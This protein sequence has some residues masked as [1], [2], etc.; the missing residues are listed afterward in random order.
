MSYWF[1]TERYTIVPNVLSLLTDG[2]DGIDV[3]VDG[4]EED[5]GNGSDWDDN[6]EGD[7]DD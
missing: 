1:S 7:E 6:D 4:D 5:Y 2:N 3:V